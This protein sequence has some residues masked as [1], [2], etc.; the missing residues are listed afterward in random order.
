MA[1]SLTSDGEVD[2]DF[3]T[4]QDAGVGGGVKH[5]GD[6]DK[7]YVKRSGQRLTTLAEKRVKQY[8][9]LFLEANLFKTVTP[10]KFDVIAAQKK[11]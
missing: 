5:K 6:S 7:V 3:A 2:A 11:K 4:G 9:N 10:A 8:F 1:Y